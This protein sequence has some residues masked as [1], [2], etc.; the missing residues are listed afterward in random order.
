MERINFAPK[1]PKLDAHSSDIEKL[2]T[3][4]LE[5]TD[6]RVDRSTYQNIKNRVSYFVQFWERQGSQYSWVLTPNALKDFERWLENDYKTHRGTILLFNTRQGILKN[7]RIA[8]R[9]AYKNDYLGSDWASFL[10][11]PKG[12]PAQHKALELADLRSIFDRALASQKHLQSCALIAVLAGTGC[13]RN[14]CSF[15]KVRNITFI[16]GD[17]SGVINLENAKGGGSRSVAFDSTAGRW[18]RLHIEQNC[19]ARVWLF[20]GRIEGHRLSGKSINE[21]LARFSNQ[22][23]I[24][25]DGAHSIRRSF[26]THWLRKLP[27]EGYGVLLAKEMGHSVPSMTLGTYNRLSIEDVRRTMEKYKCSFFAQAMA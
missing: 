6:R 12:K 10:P 3:I 9:W 1:Q 20:E 17:D 25:W 13:R 8:L 24:S 7:I 11:S 14:E 5:N 26:A 4:Y 15:I 21:T 27:G 22:S 23:G 19:A 16:S 18:I 2:F